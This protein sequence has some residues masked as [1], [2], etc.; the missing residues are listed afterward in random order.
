MEVVPYAGWSRN[1]RLTSGDLELI[2]TLEVGPR[3]MRFA[4]TGGANVLRNYEE[5][6][7]KTGGN[8]YHSY[9]GHRLWIA[10]EEDPKTMT[11][12]NEPVDSSEGDGWQKF[13]TREEPWHVQKEIAVAAVEGGF[14]IR[15]RIYNRG[16][17]AVQLAPWAI[18]VMEPGGTCAFP[19]SPF[20]PHSQRLLPVRPI[21]LWG[22][23]DM[24]DPRYTWGKQI[25]RL[26]HDSTGGNQK[27]GSLV[28]QGIAVYA[29]RDQ[30][31]VKRFDFDPACSYPDMGCNFET[32][33]RQ[34]M[35]EIES[36]GRLQMVQP[37]GYAEHC[38]AWYLL[39]NTQLPIADDDCSRLLQDLALK[40]P[41]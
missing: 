16:V 11:P 20:V 36:L 29:L 39:S 34:D 13:S 19:Q 7:G 12:D 23:T 17:Y 1:A 6:L 35:L 24:S 41:L 4:R 14:K 28:E 25:V 8:E 15:H 10:P 22:Y 18:T 26:R 30:L 2:V 21:V 33:T 32:F 38:E 5:D 37:K 3:I 27:I 40:C 9:G 31:F